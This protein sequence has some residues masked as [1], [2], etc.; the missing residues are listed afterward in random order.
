MVPHDDVR[1]FREVAE[2]RLGVLPAS[3]ANDGLVVHHLGP[4]KT[5]TCGEIG[6]QRSSVCQQ[7]ADANNERVKLKVRHNNTKLNSRI[8]SNSS[9]ANCSIRS[10]CWLMGRDRMKRGG[11]VG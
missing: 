4:F 6:R 8:L 5:A 10:A 7:E 11:G 2:G 1:D 3:I 9:L